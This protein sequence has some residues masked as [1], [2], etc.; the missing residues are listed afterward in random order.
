MERPITYLALGQLG[1]TLLGIGFAAVGVRMWTRHYPDWSENSLPSPI[2][3]AEWF[4]TYG[5]LFLV[6]IGVW[7]VVSLLV[8]QGRIRVAF[9]ELWLFVGGVLL[10]GTIFWLGI[11]SALRCIAE[12]IH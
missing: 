5:I 6:P 11:C 10:L 1:C 4:A 9:N 2:S 8:C 7:V 3:G 12:V